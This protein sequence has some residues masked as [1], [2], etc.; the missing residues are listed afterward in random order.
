MFIRP[1]GIVFAFLSLLAPLSA[2]PALTRLEPTEAELNA[3]LRTDWYGVYLQGKKIGYFR[4]SRERTDQGIRDS[5]L[6][7]MKLLSF[8]QKAEMNL[9][10]SLLFDAKAPYSLA[11]AEFREDAGGPISQF[12]MTRTASGKFDV[13]QTVG[14]V[15]RKKTAEGIDY[16]LSDPLTTELWLRRGP[17]KGDE[18]VVRELE[19]KEQRIETQRSK[20]LSFKNS[21]VAGVDVKFFEVESESSQD[22]ITVLTRHDD[23]GVM[24]S[25]KIAIFELRLEP[26]EQ[27]KNAQFSK[28]LFVLGMA[29]VDRPLG[30]LKR[31]EELVLEIDGPAK[32]FVDGPRQTIETAN[33]T[34]RLRVGKRFGK[35]IPATKE[36]IADALKETSAYHLS[37]PKVKALAARAVGDAKDD[38]AKVKNIAAFVHDYIRPSLG[39]TMPT[40][41]DLIENK[42]GD[43]KSYALLFN[44][45]ARA[46]GVPAR[47]VSGLLY[48]GDDTKAF[49]GHAWNEVVL[50]GVWVPVDA[51]LNETEANATHLSFGSDKTAAKNLLE[52]LG[53]LK[54]RVV[55]LKAR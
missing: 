17:A 48:V 2:Q 6:L 23:K 42:K 43:C 22:R 18:I 47:E 54:L 8:G 36:E 26:E 50:D 9:S 10:Q 46:S 27:A 29:K 32:V 14:Q 39:N 13:T 20:I 38:A 55:E 7:H 1:F 49:G 35:S 15:V 19:V 53:T 24:L 5:I 33:G 16:T 40:I 31:V 3:S 45:L 41:H 4:A 52:A 44:T 30:D 11:K 34:S 12:A 21:L 28:D 51:S 25:G 37:D